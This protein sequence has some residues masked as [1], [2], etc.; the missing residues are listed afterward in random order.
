MQTLYSSL[1]GTSGPACDHSFLIA[2]GPVPVFISRVA[3]HIGWCL[4]FCLVLG[5]HGDHVDFLPR[6]FGCKG[7]LMVTEGHTTMDH[8]WPWVLGWGRTRPF[9]SA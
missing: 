4:V 1:A 3:A 6:V 8:Y 2:V 9:C 5:F 7:V